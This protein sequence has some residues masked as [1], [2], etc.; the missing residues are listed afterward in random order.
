MN[1]K[2]LMNNKKQVKNCK[3]SINDLNESSTVKSLLC[4]K[5]LSKYYGDSEK[6]TVDDIPFT[7]SS[8]ASNFASKKN[9]T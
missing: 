6:T 7:I 9:Q 1:T 3:S 8:Q 2:E 4:E 5:V